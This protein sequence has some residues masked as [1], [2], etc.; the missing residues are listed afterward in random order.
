MCQSSVL[1]VCKHEITV[2]EAICHRQMTQPCALCTNPLPAFCKITP[3][4][5]RARFEDMTWN[6][7]ALLLLLS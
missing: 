5:I 2:R 7:F 6:P 1:G 4:P 3:A